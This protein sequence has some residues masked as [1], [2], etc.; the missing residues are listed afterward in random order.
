MSNSP[1]FYTN[2]Y[3]GISVVVLCLYLS[4]QVLFSRYNNANYE[5]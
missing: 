1:Q 2:A 4:P 5:N 3:P